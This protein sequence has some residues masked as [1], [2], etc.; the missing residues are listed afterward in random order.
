M[1]EKTAS[2]L[3]R[4]KH[5][6]SEG[7]AKEKTASEKKDLDEGPFKDPLNNRLYVP[8]DVNINAPHGSCF[9]EAIQDQLSLFR[10]ML[11]LLNHRELRKIAVDVQAQGRLLERKSDRQLKYMRKLTTFATEHEMTALCIAL[12][13][14]IRI[15]QTRNSNIWINA[16]LDYQEDRPT[17]RIMLDFHSINNNKNHFLTLHPLI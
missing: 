13:V 11:P 17:L 6:V 5:T 8:K 12:G 16:G 3:A 7:A 1:K 2:E 14:N 10:G 4:K 9:F 15:R